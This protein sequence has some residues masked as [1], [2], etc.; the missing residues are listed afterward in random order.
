MLDDLEVLFDENTIAQVVEGLGERISR[1]Y[2]GQELLL[3]GILKGAA[4]FVADLARSVTVPA[5]IAFIRASSYGSGTSSSGKVEVGLDPDLRF[6]CRQVLL[7]DCIIDSGRTLA[8]VREMVLERNPASLRVVV[9][10]DKKEHRT[11]GVPVD[12][13][14]FEVPDRFLVGYGLDHAGQYRNLPYIAAL[15]ADAPAGASDK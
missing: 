7:V 3:V 12:Y 5:E 14:G 2:A 4:L 8:A 10:L 9:L 6:A 1:D 15:S 11:A 13:A